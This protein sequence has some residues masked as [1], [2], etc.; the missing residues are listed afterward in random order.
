MIVGDCRP[1]LLRPRFIQLALGQVS[2]F[3]SASSSVSVS[4]LIGQKPPRPDDRNLQQAFLTATDLVARMSAA[5]RGSSRRVARS[6][7]TV[8]RA[9][10]LAH[11]GSAIDHS[12]AG[13]WME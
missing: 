4:E 3:P 7:R 12:P 13:S 9:G 8:L 11:L 5:K 10:Q 2:V 1:E 6:H